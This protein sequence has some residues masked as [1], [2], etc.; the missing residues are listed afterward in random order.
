MNNNINKKII[1][2]KHPTTTTNTN[3]DY[4]SSPSTSDAKVFDPSLETDGNVSSL[5]TVNTNQII[6][7]NPSLQSYTCAACRYFRRRCPPNCR[8][9]PYF[10]P[11]KHQ[12][13]I[14]AHKLYGVSLIIRTLNSVP[15]HLR[16][17]AMT[18]IIYSA[19]ARARDPVGG[20]KRI[21]HSL[22]AQIKFYQAQLD[23]VQAQ[24][25]YFRAQLQSQSR[26]FLDLFLSSSCC[27]STS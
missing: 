15:P 27:L 17:D 6:V 24:N 4:P 13:F 1:N 23:L 26:F 22:L 14:N 16:D 8:L 20:C 12:E 5:S 11:Q 9:A 7:N 2:L 10:P 18:S 3:S 21:L 25:F 19:N